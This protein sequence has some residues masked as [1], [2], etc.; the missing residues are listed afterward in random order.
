MTL[1]S[2]HRPSLKA[3]HKSRSMTAI[4]PSKIS[5]WLA[6]CVYFL[7]RYALL[8]FY[9][10]HLEINGQANIPPNGP[11]IL[12]PTHRSRWDAL[13]LAYAAGKLATGR[14]LRFMVSS[15]EM[16]RKLQGWFIRR[17]GGFAVNPKRPSSDSLYH[18]IDLLCQGEMLT[19]FPEGNIYHQRFVESLKRGLATIAL[20]TQAK[21]TSET[22]KIVPISINYSQLYP[23]FGCDVRVDIGKAIAVSRYATGKSTKKVSQ[24]LTADLEDA[25]RKL[26]EPQEIQEYGAY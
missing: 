24:Q 3:S 17:L 7:G 1:V 26:H 15:T 12:A 8:P 2:S 16:N 21:L 23:R 18:S 19:I 13:I 14:D 4:A 10:N 22:V 20:Q 11:V 9:F 5:P 6:H 25:L